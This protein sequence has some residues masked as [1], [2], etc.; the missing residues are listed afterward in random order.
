MAAARGEPE[1][2]AVFAT[3]LPGSTIAPLSPSML[4]DLLMESCSRYVRDK[5]DHTA[6]VCGIDSVLNGRECCRGALNFIV[7]N[8]QIRLAIL[9]PRNHMRDQK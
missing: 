6:V 5:A 2:P 3:M 4:R 9:G 7:I 1:E 8:E